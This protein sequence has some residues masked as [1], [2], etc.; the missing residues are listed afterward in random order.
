MSLSGYRDRRFK[1]RYVASLSKTLNP[2]CFNQISCETSTSREHPREECVFSA[3]SLT[4]EIAFKKQRILLISIALNNSP[5]C[6]DIYM[7]SL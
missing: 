7:K 6:I 1:P 3:M 5:V 4:E 2:H